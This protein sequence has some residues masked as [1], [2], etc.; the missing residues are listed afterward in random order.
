M[1]STKLVPPKNLVINFKPSEKQYELWQLLQPNRCNIC[2][3]PIIQK[4]IGESRAG[5]TE[6]KATCAHCGNV[7]LPQLILAGG[8]AGGGKTYL[9]SCWIISSC[10]RFPG[11]RAVIARK[12]LKSLKES[13]LNT[14]KKVLGEWGLVDGENYKINNLEGFIEFWNGSVILMKEL[15]YKPGDDSYSRLG[16]SEYS[17]AAVEEANECEEKG[18]ETLMSRLR[19]MTDSTFMVPKMLLTSNPTTNWVRSR[20]VQDDDGN[21]AKLAEGE[22][23]CPFTVDSNPDEAFRRT[24]IAALNRISD[25]ATRERLRYGNWDFVDTNNAAAYWSFNGNKHLQSNLRES[26]YDPLRPLVV[27]W[28]FNVAPFMSALVLQVDYDKK[29]VYV[30]DEIL[31]K[32]EDKE[33]NTP[34]L[35]SKVSKRL[36]SDRHMGGVIITGDPAGLARSTQTEEGVNNY[37]IIMENMHPALRAVK[38]LFPKQPPQKT[39]LEF[40]NSRFDGDSGWQ[41]LIDMRCRRLTEDMVYQRMNSDGTKEKKKIMDPKLGVKYEKYGHLSDAFDYAVCL[42]LSDDWKRFQKSGDTPIVT[43][44]HNTPVY[45][46]FEY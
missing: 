26:V 4:K 22:F 1:G 18:V 19:W 42:L 9:S 46:N 30:L 2:G 20:F 31:G 3:G 37:S 40:V 12:T 39:R 25:I 24:Y 23:Y 44:A 41:I 15:V 32:P 29:K 38:K 34:A 28:D 7:N 36:I 16:S 35:A 5:A 27:S 33:N 17:I 14:V 21:P 10:I 45:G 6:Y 8:A 11:L 43:T 13:V